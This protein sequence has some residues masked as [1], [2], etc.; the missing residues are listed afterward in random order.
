MSIKY[1]YHRYFYS[2]Y[3]A[4]LTAL[5]AILKRVSGRWCFVLHGCVFIGFINKGFIQ[6]KKGS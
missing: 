3:S 5:A 1:N 4:F 2:N 6:I